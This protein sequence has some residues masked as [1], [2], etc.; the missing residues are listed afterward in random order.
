MQGAQG[1][2]AVSDSVRDL[3]EAWMSVLDL[4]KKGAFAR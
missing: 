2:S 3:F 4:L 1:L